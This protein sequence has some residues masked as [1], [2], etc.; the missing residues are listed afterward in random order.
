MHDLPADLNPAQR[1][2]VEAADGPVLVVAGAGSGKTRVL[3]TR[4][5][6][7]LD[8]QGV[9]PGELLAFTFTNRAAREMRERVERLVGPGAAPRWMGT[10]HATGA[11]LLRIDGAAIGVPPGFTIYDSDDSLRV[12]KRAMERARL[13]PQTMPPNAVRA[14]VSRWKNDGL[15][16][17]EA[18]QRAIDLR[19]ERC[20]QVYQTYE[21]ELRKADALDFDDLILRTVELL[22]PG[23]P[24][25]QKW[26]RRFRHVL[27]D[28]FQDTNRLQMVLVK[29]LAQHHGNVFVVGDDDQSIYGWRGACIENMLEFEQVFPGTRLIRLEQNYRSTGNILA[30]ANAVIAHN[31]RRKGK[32]LWTADPCGEPLRLDHVLDEED[33]AARVVDIVRAGGSRGDV[34][35]LYRTNAQSRALEDALRRAVIPYQIVGGTHFYERREVRDLIAYLKFIANPRDAVA[36]IRVLNVPRRKIGDTT[37]A[38]LRELADASDLTLAEVAARPGLLD[39]SLPAAACRRVRAFFSLMDEWR[40][41]E[42]T[43]PLPAL[44][45]RIMVE[46]GYREWLVTDDPSTAEGRLENV[47]ELVNAAQAFVEAT[48]GGRLAGFIEQTAL[49]ADTD[50]AA[51]EEG[52]VRLMTIHTAKGLE[53]PVVILTGCEEGLLPHANSAVDERGLEE[54]RRLFYVALTRARRQVHL[55]QA[56]ARRRAGQRELSEPSRFLAEIPAELLEHGGEAYHVRESGLADYLERAAVVAPRRPVAGGAVHR[57]EAGGSESAWLQAGRAVAHPTLGAGVVT[58]VEGEGDDLLV[59]IDFPAHGRRHLLA[60]YAHLRPA[61]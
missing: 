34:T 60:R 3:T 17:A 50:A 11:K 27:V 45:E 41:A 5:A 40:A 4:V 57:S 44:L 61:P 42:A 15:L 55:L 13:D 30:A 54:E 21:A 25:Q 10:F 33:E 36:A 14:R 9:A 47:G 56:R 12:V 7:L 28:E 51:D 46:T 37:A 18:A 16:A 48:E 31:R 53:F 24:I 39:E 43:T 8:R 49:V 6:W 19:E 35:V 52:V 59:T 20:A 26:S 58:R 1:S 29:A 2:A 38:R 22:A 32:T 23:S